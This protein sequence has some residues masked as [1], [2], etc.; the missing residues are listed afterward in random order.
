LLSNE[1]FGLR[2]FAEGQVAV[3]RF[4]R[5][6]DLYDYIHATFGHRIA[7]HS[8]RSHWNQIDSIVDSFHSDDDLDVCILKTVGL[9]NL[10]DSPTLL[11]SRDVIVLAVCDGSEKRVR[12]VEE[13]LHRLHVRKHVLYYRG[14]AGGYCLWPYTSVN[15]ERAYSDAERALGSV[16]RVSV[17]I[18]SYLETRPLVARRH[19]IT[20]GNLR[21]FDVVY[22]SVD[23][24]DAAL[25]P[26]TTGAVGRIV[27]PLCETEEERRDALVFA[28]SDELARRRDV[29]VATPRPLRDLAGLLQEAQR[30]RW[31]AENTPEL[32]NDTYAE[33]EVSRQVTASRQMLEKRVHGAI[34]VQQSSGRMELQW[35]C[36]GEDVTISI[37]D[38]RH[39]LSHLSDICDRVY[40]LA[41]RL[42]NELLNRR[43]IST[44][45][46]TARFR[47][48]DLILTSSYEA[49]MGL[50]PASKPPEM[51]MY[52]S[53]LKQTGL[54]RQTDSGWALVEPDP[55]PA[56]D[57]YNVGPTLRRILTLLEGR[58]DG[59]VP[60]SHL[61]HA[62]SQPPYGVSDG[63]APVLLVVF[64]VIHARHVA[65]YEN[66]SF[67]QTLTGNDFRRLLKAPG[68]FE[69]Q[70]CRVTGVRAELFDRIAEILGLPSDDG[71]HAELLDVVRPLLVF[72]AQ[73]PEYTRRTKTLSDRTLAVRSTLVQAREP[74]PLVFRD[75]P[76]ACGCEPF[77]GDPRGD[78]AVHHFIVALRSALD[79][80]TA[81]YPTLRH[82][83]KEVVSGAFDMVGPFQHIRSSLAERAEIIAMRVDEVRLKAFCL[84]LMDDNLPENE[85]LE[86]LGSFVCSKV[87]AKWADADVVQFDQELSALRGRLGRVESMVFHEVPHNVPASA[88]HVSVT[89]AD[90][91]EVDHVLHI[92]P[93]EEIEVARMQREI[94]ALLE[95]KGRI[96]L[97]AASRVFWDILSDQDGQEKR[98]AVA[99]PPMQQ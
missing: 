89:R 34:G 13:A 2:E 87:P 17:L 95:P 42:S 9:L 16:Q 80:L 66:G 31:V 18:R 74:A 35:F 52:L 65:F 29:L 96:G 81:A 58:P 62:L 39:L 48:I 86:S 79:E 40:D 7:L 64:A 27:I 92:L 76:R 23:Q 25:E 14:A 97:L 75:L 93:E 57:P 82:H 51:S 37:S 50:D 94:A 1:P 78:D 71:Q 77:D 83:I 98:A 91:A 5:L 84:T 85:W 8:Y 59:R 56:H 36:Q 88:Y 90:G 53:V 47:L 15:L 99:S 10:L 46:A 30:W 60:V 38:R 68:T 63:V 54:H 33:E 28:Q 67:L 61:F 11:A 45:A 3:D 41:P 6:H 55:D 19:Y 72:A 49:W 26:S 24:L 43:S 22:T 20:T 69:I 21:H 73:L 70:Y 4:Y 44:A 12:R 32:T